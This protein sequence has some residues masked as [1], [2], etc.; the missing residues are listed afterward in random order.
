MKLSVIAQKTQGQLIGHDLDVYQFSTD[1]RAIQ[2]NDVFIALSGAKFDANDFVE[3]AVAAGAVAAIVTRHQPALAIPQIVVTNSHQALG[4][5]AQAWREQFDLVRVAITGSSGKTTTKELTASIFRQAGTTL[6]TLGNKNNDIG[7]PLTLLRLQAEHQYGVFELGA[8]HQGEIAYTSGLV[9]PHAALINN[10]GTAH[11]EGF[12][13]RAGIAKAKGEIF[14]GLVEG[15]TAVINADDEYADYHRQLCAGRKIINFSVNKQADVFATD[16]KRGA[17][18]AYQF[19]LHIAQQSI[20]IQLQLIG[21]HNVA[22]ALAAACLAWACG[23]SLVHIQ[24]GLNQAQG[25]AGRMVLHRCQPFTL[26]DD[27]YNANPNSVKAAIDELALCV[28]RKIVVL[29]AMGELGADAAALHQEVG[30][31]ARAKQ[32]DALYAVGAYAH[33]LA[34]GFGDNAQVFI[35]HAPLIDALKSELAQAVTVLVKGSRS[36]RMESVV[37]AFVAV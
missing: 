6:A 17:G 30:A 7:V 19:N 8:N 5:L 4:Q 10:I 26:I 31:Y 37:Q 34:T 3:Q 35:E 25:A 22:N 13:G 33:E 15:G 18:G 11:L 23:L 12:G 27:T 36:A 14:S 21:Q 28:G 1:T 16:I 32:I 2:A 20:P 29:G 24:Q 9:Q